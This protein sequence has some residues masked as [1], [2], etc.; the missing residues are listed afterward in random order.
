MPRNNDRYGVGTLRPGSQQHSSGCD[1]LCSCSLHKS[2]CLGFITA[3][4]SS[5]DHRLVNVTALLMVHSP[6]SLEG[7]IVGRRRNI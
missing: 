1:D 7:S 5:S 6:H 3:S 2:V 4:R